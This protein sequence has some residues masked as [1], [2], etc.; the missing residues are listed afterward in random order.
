MSQK[1]YNHLFSKG[2]INGLTIKNRIV[3]APMGNGLGQ[4][5]G[6][7]SEREIAYYEARAKGGCGLI[8]TGYSA[9]SG[10][11]LSG[12]THTNQMHVFEDGHR[13]ALQA[14]AERIHQYDSKIFVQLHHPGF[15]ADPHLNNG[16]QPLSASAVSYLPGLPVAKELTVE[17]IKQIVQAFGRAAEHCFYA[18]IDGVLVHGAHNYLID[19]FMNPLF[20][21]RTDEYGGNF[22]NRM[23]FSVEVLEEIRSKVPRS[24]PVILRINAEDFLPGGINL[25]LAVENAKYLST[26]GI[27]AIDVSCSAYPET[28]AQKPGWRNYMAKSI[29]E[30]VDLPII[31]VNTIKEPEYAEHLL[32]TGISDFVSLGREYIAEPEWAN[33][34][35]EGSENEIRPCLSC[36]TC[37]ALFNDLVG[38]RCAI[39]PNTGR[40]FESC[41]IEQ[42][43]NGQN[44]VVIGAGPAGIE[45]ALTASKKG[46]KVT[47]FE[48]S[49]D[50]GGSLQLA[51]KA[52][53]KEQIDK[54]IAYYRKQL[55]NNQVELKLNTDISDI[56]PINKLNPY[57]VIL[58]AG[59]T[60][61][62]PKLQG[63]DQSNVYTAPSILSGEIKLEGQKVMII[64]SGMTGFETAEV[65]LL[66]DNKVSI[67]DM[68]PVL[69]MGMDYSTRQGIFSKME[70]CCVPLNP[71]HKLE[72][73]SENAAEF[74][75]LLTNEK[76]KVTADSFVLSLGI[77]PENR[78]LDTLEQHFDKVIN[79]GDSNQP[80]KIQNATS[81][82]YYKINAAL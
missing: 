67:Y 54:L 75:N 9:V 55:K 4:L 53:D 27:D 68:M 57:A 64:G 63:I 8:Y 28:P 34:A 73:I 62:L 65:L 41:P 46:Y 23:R 80:G 11:A 30:V 81:D 33:K 56:A 3:M 38:I 66:G 49:S 82:G 19:Q 69:G 79:I 17:E 36:N 15:L 6:E 1:K 35:R 32:A 78:L 40:E 29:K 10:P 70:K 7:V 52:P 24:Y 12:L 25:G 37:H 21:H 22:E 61:I 72:K 45:A 48:K 2:K 47:I 77:V 14:L 58:A 39:N 44:V 26:K 71:S 5:G 18:G 50:I 76:I 16:N 59:G 60:P 31:A 13:T 20:N 42:T 51:N 43:G 74:K